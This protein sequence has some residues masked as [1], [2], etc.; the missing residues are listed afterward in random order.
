MIYNPYFEKHLIDAVVVPF[1]VKADDYVDVFKVTTV[2]L[3]D[4]VSTTVKIAGSCN[5]VLL[6]TKSGQSTMTLTDPDH[7]ATIAAEFDRMLCRIASSVNAI[8]INSSGVVPV[9][10]AGP[11]VTSFWNYS[12]SNRKPLPP[13]ASTVSSVVATVAPR[14]MVRA[15][16]PPSGG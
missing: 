15:G 10:C 16:G 12:A 4:E 6:L 8:S 14:R 1:G 2:G 5:A 13:G 3:L 9:Q 7:G 11:S